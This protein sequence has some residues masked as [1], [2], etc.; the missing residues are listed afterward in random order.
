MRKNHKPPRDLERV[1]AERDERWRQEMKQQFVAW[2]AE[3]ARAV[4]EEREA[5]ARILDAEAETL[6]TIYNFTGPRTD[7]AIKARIKRIAEAIRAR[8]THGQECPLNERQG[9]AL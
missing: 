6:P 3:V 2:R 1:K 4:A 5:C 9:G 7:G 8:G